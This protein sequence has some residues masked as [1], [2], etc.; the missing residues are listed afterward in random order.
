MSLSKS[1]SMP[2][3]TP[4]LRLAYT[5]TKLYCLV[6]EAR[7]CQQLTQCCKS[8]TLATR[9]TSHTILQYKCHYC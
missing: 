5:G 1:V 8:N 9:P 4:D 2:S 7:V 6:T 3:A